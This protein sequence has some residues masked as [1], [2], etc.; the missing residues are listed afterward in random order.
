[1]I[2]H[3]FTSCKGVIKNSMAPTR[4]ALCKWF[5]NQGIKIVKLNLLGS[6]LKVITVSLKFLSSKIIVLLYFSRVFL[7]NSNVRSILIIYQKLSVKNYLSEL[8]G[9]LSFSMCPSLRTMY[10]SLI[11]LIMISWFLQAWFTTILATTLSQS[12]SINHRRSL[13]LFSV[14]C[15]IQILGN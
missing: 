6:I 9:T 10:Q 11:I 5:L 12:R 1:M 3:L 8:F 15:L 14:I 2:R 7:R 4:N 13:L